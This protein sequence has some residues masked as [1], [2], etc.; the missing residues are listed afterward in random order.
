MMID[1]LYDQPWEDLPSQQQME[2]AIRATLPDGQGA[3]C[4]RLA[5]NPAVA[6]LNKRWRQIDKVTDV[7]A[8]PMQEGK[9]DPRQP[10]GDLI[11][12]I[13]F[14][15]QEAARLGLPFPDHL[16]HL[17]IHGTLHLL[18]FDHAEADECHAMSQRERCIMQRLQLHDP[19][20]TL[21]RTETPT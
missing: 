11:L 12:A 9:I 3:L 2:A 14:V 21:S 4:V 8:F 18:G 17:L 16:I 1:F 19:W 7:L 10:L 5:D 13:P 6:Q 20:P 15:R